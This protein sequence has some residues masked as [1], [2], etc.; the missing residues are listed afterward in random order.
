MGGLDSEERDGR[1]EAM[2]GCT[3]SFVFFGF[4]LAPGEAYLSSKS[5]DDCHVREP[6]E[7]HRST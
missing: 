5:I 4:K 1:G 3:I 7:A 6:Q 2:G